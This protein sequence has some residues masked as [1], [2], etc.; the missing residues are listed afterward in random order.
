MRKGAEEP[1][2]VPSPASPLSRAGEG[3]GEGDEIDQA[4]NGAS[5]R[6]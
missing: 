3:E 5:K 2:R 6:N 4:Q 1:S